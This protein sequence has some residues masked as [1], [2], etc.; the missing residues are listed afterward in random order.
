MI[1]VYPGS[2]DPVTYGHINIAERGAKIFDHLFIAVLDNPDK[3]PLFSAA[4]RVA[5]LQQSLAHLP[6]VSVTA[7][8]G[9]LADF[10]KQANTNIIL[11]GLRGAADFESEA[12]YAAANRK[13]SGAETLYLPAEPSL[14]YVSSRIVREIAMHIYK[15]EY[16]D[17]T[18]LSA[19]VPDVVLVAL[20][21]RR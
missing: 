8:C 20:R 9:L 7:F 17:D 21:A 4:E 2:F 1:A 5:L 6:N 14:M 19:M 13:L 16:A 11:R 12:P 3:Q 15:N 18:A 10:V